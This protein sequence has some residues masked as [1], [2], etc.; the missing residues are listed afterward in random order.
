MKLFLGVCLLAAAMMS[1]GCQSMNTGIH[2][3]GP[4]SYT[5]TRISAGFFRVYGT[6]YHCEPRGNSMNCTKI[7]SE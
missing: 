3:D 6:V 1:M 7:D 2:K 4:N 5:M